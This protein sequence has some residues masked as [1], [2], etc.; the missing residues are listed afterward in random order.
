MEKNRKKNVNYF[1]LQKKLTPQHSKSRGGG[2]RGGGEGEGGGRR[3]EDWGGRGGGK[4]EKES[5]QSDVIPVSWRFPW[6]ARMW[7]DIFSSRYFPVLIHYIEHASFYANT[8]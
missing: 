1:A 7:S 5:H 3:E 6:M 2:G 4:E 8:E